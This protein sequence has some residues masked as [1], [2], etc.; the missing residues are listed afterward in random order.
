MSDVAV[1]RSRAGSSSFSSDRVAGWSGIGFAILLVIQN[2]L[3]SAGAPANDAPAGDV[4][5]YLTASQGTLAILLALFVPGL[6]ALFAF[7]SGLLARARRMG[8]DTPW[9]TFGLTGAIL[10]GALFSASNAIEAALAAM[11]PQLGSDPTL[12]SFIWRLH[13]ATFA[14]NFAAIGVALLGLSRN[15]TGR[16]PDPR[17]R[18]PP[19][20]SSARSSCLPAPSRSSP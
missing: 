12:V 6:L 1:A 5:A 9:A 16:P 18:G 13:T 4:L 15:S 8:I 14:L 20:A 19:G 17:I 3:R 2:A 11:A 7:I 10:I